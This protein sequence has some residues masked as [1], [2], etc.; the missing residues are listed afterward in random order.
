MARA[1]VVEKAA[2][3]TAAIAKVVGGGPF[4]VPPV[5]MLAVQRINPAPYNPRKMS[6]FKFEALKANIRQNGFLENLVIQKLSKRYGP[7]VIIGGHQRVRAVREICVEDNVHMP[8]LPGVVLDL[9]DRDAQILNV[10]LNNIDGE[11]DAKLVGELLENVQHES[12]VLPEEKLLMGFEEDDF[13][14][15]MKLSEPPRIDGDT[16]AIVG[17]ATLLLEFRDKK[18]RDAVKERLEERAKL[19]RKSNGDVV[20]ELFGPGKK[21]RSA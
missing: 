14:K 9:N 6:P 3:K 12:V 15:Y 11:F 19:S 7:L 5:V 4:S 2:A 1:S 16:P 8:E 21:K 20:L 13:S 17:K 10:A 18:T